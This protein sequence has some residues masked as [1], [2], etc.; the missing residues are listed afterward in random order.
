VGDETHDRQ[1]QTSEQDG[2]NG[3]GGELVEGAEQGLSGFVHLE[4]SLVWG[5]PRWP[6]MSKVYG[7]IEKRSNYI[8]VNDIKHPQ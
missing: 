4:I 6:S 7:R 3:G 1:G 8:S 5:R 2:Q